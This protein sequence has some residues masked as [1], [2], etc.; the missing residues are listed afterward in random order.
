MNSTLERDYRQLCEKAGLRTTHEPVR[1]RGLSA[2]QRNGSACVENKPLTPSPRR[3][4][5]DDERALFSLRLANLETIQN[6][7]D[8]DTLQDNLEAAFEQYAPSPMLPQYTTEKLQ[9]FAEARDRPFEPNLQTGWRSTS[10]VL[11][12]ASS[13]LIYSHSSPMLISQVLGNHRQNHPVDVML[14]RARPITRQ[15]NLRRRR[16]S[17]NQHQI[18][19]MAVEG[20][21]PMT[22]STRAR[23]KA[24]MQYI[25]MYP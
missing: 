9:L 4:T 1:K 2:L 19:S 7:A 6:K 10:R 21:R 18:H 22:S 25:N 23:C 11:Q 16:I 17:S 8:I 13:Q 5:L 12:M 3:M 15:H 20:Q 14:R 24:P